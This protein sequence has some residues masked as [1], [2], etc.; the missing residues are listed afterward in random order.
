MQREYMTDRQRR[1]YMRN[2]RRKK[3]LQQRIIMCLMTVC[4]ILTCAVSYHSIKTSANTGEEQLRFK[5]YTNVSVQPGETLWELADRYMD[6]VQYT[7]KSAYIEEVLRMNH[8]EEADVIRAGQTLIVP[9]YSAE[10]K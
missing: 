5:Y 4:L 10:F 6:D 8:L 7:S 1:V 3:V 2:R 9:Y